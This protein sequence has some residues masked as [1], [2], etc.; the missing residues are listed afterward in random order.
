MNTT[1]GSVF[2]FSAFFIVASTLGAAW[3][4]KRLTNT[5]GNSNNARLAADGLNIYA[6]WEDDN[7][8]NAEIYFKRSTD[9]GLTWLA[10]K[11]ITNS[12]NDSHGPAITVNGS[13][14]Y[15]TWYED[16]TG[17]SQ[18][19][20][21][22][23]E[24]GGATWKAVKQVTDNAGFSGAPVIAVNGAN[25][26]LAWVDR[27][28]GNNEI[29]FMRSIDG[30]ATWQAAKRLTNTA[31]SSM[32]PAIAV[33]GA[34]IYLAWYDDTPGNAEIYVRKS[35]NGGTSWQAAV[36]LSF[37][38]GGSYAP[39]IAVKNNAVY[40]SWSDNSPSAGGYTEV[41]FRKSPDG[42]T[43]WLTEKRLTNTA[44]N[45]NTPALAY[46]GT[47]VFVAWSD[48][49]PGNNE[50]YLRK[51][52]NSGGSFAGSERLTNNS[53]FSYEPDV[54]ISGTNIY[55]IWHDNT[56]GNNEIYIKYSL[57]E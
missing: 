4:T 50:I 31:G 7:P 24:D 19:F 21:R 37:N 38:A 13:N 52:T 47:N 48:A 20:F 55:V 29:Y 17:E 6:V 10:T 43:S 1:K 22:R 32:D 56:P 25:V 30:G 2:L 27:T 53:G 33:N 28:P 9:G 15:V 35:T 18:V 44:F 46:T 54:V 45:S 23:S 26:Y 11:K 39:A 51:S 41:Y 16:M 12:A 3:Q 36:R 40:V 49:T 42:G 34:N 14:I 5:A 57:I 8:G